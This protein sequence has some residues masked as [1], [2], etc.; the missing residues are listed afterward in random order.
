MEFEHLRA[1]GA[2]LRGAEG[3]ESD[4]ARVRVPASD[5]EFAEV[6]VERYEYS[7]VRVRRRE[8]LV[9]ARVGGPLAGPDDVMASGDQG[10]ARAAPDARVEE[11]LHEPVPVSKGSIRS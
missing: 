8:Y 3:D 9:V 11:D 7:A 5:G 6:F 2:L 1:R 10:G 4:D